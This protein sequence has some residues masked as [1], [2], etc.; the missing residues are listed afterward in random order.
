MVKSAH[1]TY[2]KYDEE[3][4]TNVAISYFPTTVLILVLVGLVLA[5]L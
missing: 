3:V 4:A 1:I 2:D 5:V